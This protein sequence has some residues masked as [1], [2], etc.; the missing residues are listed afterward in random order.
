MILQYRKKNTR[1]ICAPP[2]SPP[3]AP[4]PQQQRGHLEA[5]EMSDIKAIQEC[6]VK[7]VF[8]L[9]RARDGLKTGGLALVTS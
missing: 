9:S 4:G 7:E 5:T 2:A 3:C 8:S 1:W 6:I